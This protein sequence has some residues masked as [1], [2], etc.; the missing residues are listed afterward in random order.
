[1][2]GQQNIKIGTTTLSVGLNFLCE[3]SSIDCEVI[4]SGTYYRLKTQYILTTCQNL[5]VELLGDMFRLSNSHHQAKVEHSLG[6]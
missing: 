6:T 5:I 2:H 3:L 1:M 4:Y